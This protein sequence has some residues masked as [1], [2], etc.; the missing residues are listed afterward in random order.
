MQSCPSFALTA[1]DIEHAFQRRR[2]FSGISLSISN[3]R[4]L[5]ITGRNGSG[6]S[7]LLRILS[8][9]L[10]PSR[11]TIELSVDNTTV[12]RDNYYRHIGFVSPYI[13]LY[14]E[15]TAMEHVRINA[16]LR[17]V[18]FDERATV[19]TL[20]LLRLDH[21]RH[22]DIKTYSS[23]MKQRMKYALALLHSP[24]LLLLDEPMTNLDQEGIT[25]V[26]NIVALHR[27]R[28]GGVIIATNDERDKSLCDTLLSVEPQ[29]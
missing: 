10:S 17:A 8:N 20:A 3:N 26:E 1:T 24:A 28:G 14:E 5:G 22:D 23:G 18:P 7:T 15:F 25:T 29:Q 27:K 21:R 12:K 6:K 19:E 11:G 16:Q 13:A 4:T 9:L 2:I